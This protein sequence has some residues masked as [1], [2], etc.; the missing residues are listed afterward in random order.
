V[1]GRRT[2]VLQVLIPLPGWPLIPLFLDW[3]SDANISH[4][5]DFAVDDRRDPDP[6]AD[7][8]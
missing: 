4:I 7:Q 2:T 8:G 3:V 1:A 5:T 6:A